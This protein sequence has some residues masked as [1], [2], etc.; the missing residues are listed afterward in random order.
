MN[1]IDVF[2]GDADGICALIQLRLA[3]PVEA[4][5]VTGV[6]RDVALLDRVDGG[7]GDTVTVLDVSL[8]VNRAALS[9]L[10]DAG[11]HVDY[12]DHH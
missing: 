12:F 11:A 6:K 2:N 9:R 3:M 10:L 8:D 1:H 5:L 4:T 7:H